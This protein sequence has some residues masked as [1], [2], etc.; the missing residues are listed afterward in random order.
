MPLNNLVTSLYVMKTI[1]AINA[2][3]PIIF[4]IASFSWSIFF[5]P[6][7]H[8]MKSNNNLPPSNA[9]NGTKFIIPRF[10]LIIEPKYSR[11]IIPVLAASYC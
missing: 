7:I 11:L 2:Q 10:K 4:I 8:S 5:P 3:N 1:K 6:L 9:G